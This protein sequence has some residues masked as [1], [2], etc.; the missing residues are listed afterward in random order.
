M[1][2]TLEEPEFC[3]S[4]KIA[5]K[6]TKAKNLI[7]KKNG[8][9]YQKSLAAGLFITLFHQLTG[10]RYPLKFDFAKHNPISVKKM[11]RL[12]QQLSITYA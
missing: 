6:I 4:E 10:L 9:F 7:K 1:Y 8:N 2:T 5:V 11:W 12:K 3:Q